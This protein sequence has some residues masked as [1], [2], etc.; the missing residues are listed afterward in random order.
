MDGWMGE[1]EGERCL[2]LFIFYVSSCN[3]PDLFEPNLGQ[4]SIFELA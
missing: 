4:I 1:G 3:T 2:F